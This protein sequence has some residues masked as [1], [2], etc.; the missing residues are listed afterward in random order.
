MKYY[1]TV[2]I[3][4]ALLLSACTQDAPRSTDSADTVVVDTPAAD[5]A[6]PVDTTSVDTLEWTTEPKDVD[7][8]I[9]QIAVVDE[10][11]TGR[12]QGYDRFVVEFQ[13]DVIPG[14]QVSY[15]NEDPFECGSGE[16]VNM[17]GDAVLEI[18]LEPAR[19]HNEQGQSTVDHAERQFDL[20]I[21]QE[22]EVSCDFEGMF[23]ALLGLQER[24]QFRVSELQEPARLV[25]DLKH[26]SSQ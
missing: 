16:P 14:Y 5:T 12:H 18:R 6:Q 25:V 19:G 2:L 22:A 8:S 10:L 9:P 4:A 20:P 7:R 26:A 15:L 23:T 1:A 17:A 11:R 3:T 21:L 24:V 13:N